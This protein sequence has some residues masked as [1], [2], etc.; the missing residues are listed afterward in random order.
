[1]RVPV[2]RPSASRRSNTLLLAPL[3]KAASWGAV[4]A[5]GTG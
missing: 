1:M 4:S 3:V 2:P 5:L